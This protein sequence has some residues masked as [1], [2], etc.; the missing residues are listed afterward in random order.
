MKNK[1]SRSE[2]SAYQPHR[3]SFFRAGGVDQVRIEKGADIINLDQ[4]DQK[5]WV[6][7]SCPTRGLEMD[8]RTLEFLDA[9][10]DGHVRPPEILKAAS[11]LGDVLVNP[12][13]LVEGRDGV[14]L[15]NLREDTEEGRMLK[16]SAEHMLSSLDLDTSSISVSDARRTQ[17]YFATAEQNGDGV[18]P[19]DTIGDDSARSVAEDLVK[20]LGGKED[21]SGKPGY[22]NAMLE[23]FFKALAEYDEWLRSGEKDKQAIL[24]LGVKTESA[25]A[26]FIA[27]RQKIDDYFGRCRLAAFDSRA[28]AAVNREESAYIEVAARDLNITAD[29]LQH[30]PLALVE[31]GKPLPLLK[32]INPSWTARI[33]AFRESCCPDLEI[34]NEEDWMKLRT[35]FDAH[36]AWLAAKSGAI[37]EP[38]GRDRVREILKGNAREVLEKAIEEDLAVAEWVNA[39]V[40][41]EKLAY[42]HRDFHTLLQNY[43]SFT[44]FYSRKG[45]IF[46]AGT[47]YLDGRACDMCFHVNNAARHLK[48]APMSNAF[49]AYVECV[50]PGAEKLSLACAFTAGDSDN[51]FEGRNGIFYDRKGMD[52]DATIVRIISNPISIREAFWSPYKKVLRSIQEA[53]A[54]RAA[55]ADKASTD[56]LTSGAA[57]VG[58]AAKTGTATTKTKFEVGTIAALGVA[59][60]GIAGVFTALLTGF[61]GLGI[62]IPFGILGLLLAISG[63]SMFIAWL[64]LRTRNLGPILDANGWAVNTLTRVNIPLGTSLTELPRIPGGSARTL[65]D[66]FAPKKS[67]WP[68]L[69]FLLLIAGAAGYALYRTNILH[70]WFPEHIPAHHTELAVK[71]DRIMAAPGENVEFTVPSASKNLYVTDNSDSNSPR[72]MPV[73]TVEEGKAT[74][75]IPEDMKSGTLTVHDTLSGSSVRISILPAKPAQ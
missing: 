54:K 33:N 70:Q 8:S 53:I 11:W 66:P 67:F 75:T 19:P 9:D 29:E 28:L 65:N 68:Q 49:L 4:L 27:V 23:V 69:I 10:G 36:A 59:V 17:E 72:E 2:K 61:L 43:V 31:A 47:L 71:A 45:A 6:A 74:L 24:P 50:R 30:F 1:S 55:E 41:V 12:D 7:L 32:E 40:K 63:P 73:L 37:V 38:L 58:E 44:D 3:W 22:D 26:A 15:S 34:L 20:C 60:S 18:V 46:Q 25:F 35:T 64:K 48:M 13:C 57:S 5:L 16:A 51:L 21:R 56:R 42:L 39:M 52:W 62:W 14:M